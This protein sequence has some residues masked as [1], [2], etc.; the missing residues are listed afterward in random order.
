MKKRRKE[1]III[2]IFTVCILFLF[3]NK[4]EYS[5]AT[6]Y[7]NAKEFYESTGK[8]GESYHADISNGM[9]YLGT[10][11]KLASSSSNLKYYTVGY[12]IT[13]LG[14]G[15]S[16][17]FA[18]KRGHSMELVSDVTS[19]GYNYLLYRINTKTLY[20][21]A[22][23]AD[24]E[25]AAEVLESS[26]ITVIANAIMTT[27]RGATLNGNVTEDGLGGLS[28]WGTIYHLENDAEWKE[29]MKIFSGHEFKSYRNIEEEL[30]NYQL[31][32]R[33][34]TNGMKNSN[35]GGSSVSTVGN[36]YV[37]KNVIVNE[38][39]TENVLHKD[40]VPV[41]TSAKVVNE[42]QLI[43]PNTID[44][45]KI[46]YHLKSGKE[47]I[48]NNQTFSSSVCYMPK[49]IH[50]GL[51]YGSRNIYM[52]AN[53]QPNTYTISYNA[54]GG[55][56]IVAD[57]GFLYDMSGLLRKNT[58]TRRGYHLKEGKEWNTKADG[59][60]ISYSSEEMVK[61]I[62]SENGQT[63]ILYA[64]WEADVYE[65]TTDKQGGTGGSDIFYEK[66]AFGWYKEKSLQNMIKNIA[67]PSKAGYL[68]LGY[69]G[70]IYG[71]GTSI[72]SAVGDL[73]I[74]PD[75]FSTNSI[76]YA[77]Y[78]AKQYEV[79]FDKRGG[80]GG[81]DS[82]VA[83]YGKL[84]P[85]AVAPLR[86]GYTFLGYYMDEACEED[87]YYS[88]HM[89]GEKEYLIDG[90]AT[91]YAKWTDDIPP[92]VTIAAETEHWTNSKDG[93]TI[94]VTAADLGTGLDSVNVYR[95]DV[96]VNSLTGL[97]GAKEKSFTINHVVEGVF[98]YKAV[99][100]DKQGN[101]AQAYVNCRYDIKAPQKIVME[102]TNE[103][104]EELK[105][106]CITVEIT[107]YNVQ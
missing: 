72:V 26:V 18:V 41:T 35:I 21:L 9:F 55:D 74:Q 20:D 30:E 17:K 73:E 90:N 32:I 64:N 102:V 13:L 101:C 97:D 63:I 75:Y 22:V 71:L 82:V 94:T 104:L 53:W 12:D 37:Q 107:D 16:I 4:K 95:D 60:G 66:Y 85:E 80:I 96:L 105:N 69:Y 42:I 25:A 27:K 76:I 81:T 1:C 10:K 99:A 2:G 91:L 29:M 52:Y 15:T 100:V 103:T 65:I 83:T 61:N 78:K 38:E 68:F 19:S 51:G 77:Y 28:E 14:N 43:S 5:A 6:S 67:I 24:E 48:Y 7:N 39:V 87:R 59:T 47:W 23:K 40:G 45:K 98:R 79:T 31:S 70:N 34:V 46:G 44:L 50:S 58:Y 36:G 93:I 56:G 86:N 57:S 33:Y 49:E 84:L 89:A 88:K 11:A 62:T 54:N 92:V 106:F 3:M 8:Q